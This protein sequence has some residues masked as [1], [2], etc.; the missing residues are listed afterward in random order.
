MIECS[1][2]GPVLVFL[3]HSENFLFIFVRTMTGMDIEQLILEK[4][5]REDTL[6]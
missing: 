6:S 5:W 2:E 4:S 1:C 3:F